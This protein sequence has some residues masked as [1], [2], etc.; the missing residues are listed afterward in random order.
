MKTINTLL[1]GGGGREY[2]IAWKISQSK[3]LGKFFSING[4]DGISKYATNVKNIN[5][6]EFDKVLDFCTKNEID[7]VVIGPEEPIVKGL[8]DF[9]RS[10]DINVFA[11][12]MEGSKIESSKEFTKIICDKTGIPTA[13]Y[14]T[15]T[16]LK[17]ILEYLETLDKFPVVLKYDGLAAGKGVK[18][19]MSKSDAIRDA[20][21]LFKSYGNKNFKLVVEE[22]LEGRELSFFALLDGYSTVKF[23]V[24]QDYK[25]AYD[26]DLGENTGG[27]GAISGDFLMNQELE[28]KVMSRIIKPLTKYLQDNKI[29]YRG[30]IFAG[31][32]INPE[33]NPHLIEFNCRFGDPETEAMCM[34]LKSDLLGILYNTAI[35]RLS[36]SEIDFFSEPS[37]CIVMAANGYPGE[38]KKGDRI[39]LLPKCSKNSR[40]FHHGTKFHDGSWYSNGGRLLSV[41]VLGS[42]LEDARKKAY[43]KIGKINFDGGFYRRDIGKT[44]N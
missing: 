24:A 10:N 22:F 38:Y 17:S 30:V 26:N 9:L 19:S 39:G 6:H 36:E 41:N 43:E 11:P 13:G 18:V 4:S 31:L 7:L 32:M 27:M 33:G 28:D 2:A 20:N 37:I 23:G 15:F 44:V 8:S 40:I 34:R 21:D 1:I 16:D 5:W 14:K 35:G 25:R 29:V 12:S 42:D 3:L